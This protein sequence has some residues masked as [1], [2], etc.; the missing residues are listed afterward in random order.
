[1]VHSLSLRLVVPVLVDSETGV[2]CSL[3]L[4]LI[5]PAI[6][7]SRVIVSEAGV[8]CGSLS[9]MLVVPEVVVPCNSLF[10]TL[11]VP[12]PRP[13]SCSARGRFKSGFKEI[14]GWLWG[15]H[16]QPARLGLLPVPAPGRFCVGVG[17]DSVSESWGVLLTQART[18]TWGFAAEN[19]GFEST[20]SWWA[21]HRE[22]GTLP[23]T[24]PGPG[25]KPWEGPLV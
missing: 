4:W 8:P 9:L 14:Q 18:T 6:N 25:F 7:C 3:S 5:V 19:S 11:V 23:V 15:I 2:P 1:M 12:A 21:L 13:K 17:L 16:L 22:E 20:V 10:P 24:S